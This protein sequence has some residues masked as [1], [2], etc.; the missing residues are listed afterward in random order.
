MHRSIKIICVIVA[1][2]ISLIYIGSFRVKAVAS[3]VLGL[4]G[5]IACIEC[6]GS[7]IIGSSSQIAVNSNSGVSLDD[8]GL[9]T[10]GGSASLTSDQLMSYYL[11][12]IDPSDV[13]GMSDQEALIYV[14]DP[15]RFDN[16][17]SEYIS[18]PVSIGVEYGCKSYLSEIHL[19]AEQGK[20]ISDFSG[21]VL[22]PSTFSDIVNSVS[23]DVI[24]GITGRDASISVTENGLRTLTISSSFSY[25]SSLA[26]EYGASYVYC[27]DFWVDS[28][29]DEPM[30]FYC[31]FLVSDG[32][33]VYFLNA[34]DI[35]SNS[36]YIP[37]S[38]SFYFSGT[39]SKGIGLYFKSQSVSSPYYLSVFEKYKRRQDG[40]FNSMSYPQS[41]IRIHSLFSAD[42]FAYPYDSVLE[43]GCDVYSVLFDTKSEADKLFDDLAS[44]AIALSPSDVNDTDDDVISI[45]DSV[46][47][48][49]AVAD[50]YG[51]EKDIVVSP[52]AVMADDGTTTYDPSITIDDTDVQDTADDEKFKEWQNQRGFTMGLE[53]KFRIYDQ[54]KNLLENLFNYDDVN[55]P[56]SFKFYYD[57]NNDGTSETYD[58]L[59]LSVLETTLTNDHMEDKSWWGTDIKVIDVIRYV[60]AAILYGLF[61]M[62]LIK[63]LPTFYGSGPWGTV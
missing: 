41:I 51:G 47:V 13:A 24:S 55:T 9:G 34:I 42:G 54:I 59:D 19:A 36:K 31:V 39:P 37:S 21:L 7:S 5:L 61:I 25:F 35:Y 50:Y 8:F 56:P 30:D 52:G 11:S 28:D 12:S 60:I 2:C 44:Q 45:P 43:S 48:P 53:P 46:T 57:S 20:V 58:V 27:N 14:T 62:R 1:S 63:R 33:Q 10:S 17:L 38:E 32:S 22:S 49:E 6:L 16:Y 29:F 26:T 40:S 15:D 23:S 18:S 3:S 4:S